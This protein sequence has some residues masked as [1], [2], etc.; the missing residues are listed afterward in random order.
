M[1]ECKKR[2]LFEAM[3][4]NPD[5]SRE[6]GRLYEKIT[7]GVRKEFNKLVSNLKELH[8]K[9]ETMGEYINDFHARLPASAT[10]VSLRESLTDFS[11]KYKIKIDD[12][13]AG[14]YIFMYGCIFG[15]LPERKK[16]LK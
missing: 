3:K 16:T 5:L 7:L 10:Y 14:Y 2:S 9:G 11:D 1:T 8:E 12:L 13:T 15:K 6:L 4:E